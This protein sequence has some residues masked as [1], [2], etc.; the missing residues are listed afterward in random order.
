MKKK[1][2]VGIFVALTLAAQSTTVFAASSTSSGDSEPSYSSSGSGTAANEVTV[3]SDGVKVTAVMTSTT[4]G[5]SSIAIAVQ[6]T[7]ESGQSI[8]TNSK[9]E[10]VIGNK[11]ISFAKNAAA[12]A[13]LPDDVVRAIG[14]INNGVSLDSIISGY[15]ITKEKERIK[16]DSVD[17]NNAPRLSLTGYSALTGTHAL[18]MKNAATGKVEDTSSET[19]I[20]VPNLVEGLE[21]VSVLYYN[22]ATGNWLLLP[23]SKVDAKS[24]LVYVTVPG[25]GTLSVVYKR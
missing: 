19:V 15:D 20:Y 25:S 22:N 5:G 17:L 21:N 13:G 12:T 4:S 2:A 14:D 3:N 16:A 11:V 8:R 6:A 10:A 24:K 9:G 23:V 1:A 7:T 18:V